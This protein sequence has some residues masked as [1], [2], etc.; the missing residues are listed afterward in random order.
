MKR[1]ARDSLYGRKDFQQMEEKM[2]VHAR[3]VYSATVLAKN[4]VRI[5]DTVEDSVFAQAGYGPT[6]DVIGPSYYVGLGV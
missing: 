4:S 3:P 5:E 2:S 6:T 1:I